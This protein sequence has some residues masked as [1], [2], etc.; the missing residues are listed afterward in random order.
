MKRRRFLVSSLALACCARGSRTRGEVKVYSIGWLTAQRAAS[1]APYLDAF[2]SGLA[3]LGY[4]EGYN[5]V[6]A[7]RYADGAIERVPGLSAEL[8]RIPVDLIVAQGAA[9][10]EIRGLTVPVVYAISADPVLSGFAESLAR[11]RGNMTGLTFMAVE[12]V[13]KRLEVLREIIPQLRRVAVLG[14]PEHPGAQLE[15]GFSEATARRLGVE[16]AYFPTRSPDELSAALAMMAENPQQAISLLADGFAVENRQ[17]IIDFATSHHVPV[18]SGWPVFA[19][20][21]AIC[22]YG[23][24]LTASYRRLAYY[25][26]RILKGAKLADLPIE[27][28]TEF[29]LVVNLKS[30][31]TLG[32]TIPQALEARA[33][34]VIE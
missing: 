2:R 7:Y 17:V 9:A 31:K 16:I 28:P 32:I 3:D 18:I 30:A 15:R 34:S 4:I 21:G 6:I 26:D 13:G 5:L 20:S 23:P 25:I 22:T 14:N 19:Q 33:D 10:F 24:R 27:Q 8:V 12:L 29:D 1:L 11:P